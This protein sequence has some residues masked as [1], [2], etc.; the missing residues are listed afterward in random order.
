LPGNAGVEQQAVGIVVI[1]AHQHAVGFLGQPE[2]VVAGHLAKGRYMQQLAAA[3]GA[4]VDDGAAIRV[5]QQVGMVFAKGV[6]DVG[7]YGNQLAMAVVAVPEADRIEGIAEQR[8]KVCS[9]T[10]PS[11]GRPASR[12]CWRIQG[13]SG[14]PS[15]GP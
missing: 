14:L 11:A 15:R 7:Q 10:S 5:G 12:S 3:Q 9:Q 8:G 13:S 6:V 2:T 1:D 4:A